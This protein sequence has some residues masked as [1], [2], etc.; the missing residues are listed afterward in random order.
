MRAALTASRSITVST[1]DGPLFVYSYGAPRPGL[2]GGS[3]PTPITWLPP[4]TEPGS[5]THLALTELSAT[6]DAATIAH[7]LRW[8]AVDEWRS[9]TTVPA[10]DAW[11]LLFENTVT[12]VTGRPLPLTGP[13][14]LL[15]GITAPP[16]ARA[17]W[18]AAH[19]PAATVVV[20][21]D[22]ANLAHPPHWSAG[23][24]PAPSGALLGAHRTA[25]FR[26]ALVIAPP[27][28]PVAPLAALGRAALAGPAPARA[29]VCPGERTPRRRPH[30]PGATRP[31]AAHHRAPTA[32]QRCAPRWP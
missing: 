18:R 30:S 9:L 13:S 5:A 32:R 4:L 17:E 3:L 19:L 28:R 22:S 1:G 29:V 14:L 2:T 16:A 7:H 10:G 15:P 23:L 27:G 31:A 25:A 6:P 20:V 8:P 26:Y 21:D 12:D 24:S 11:L